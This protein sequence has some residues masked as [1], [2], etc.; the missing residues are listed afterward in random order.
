LYDDLDYWIFIGIGDDIVTLK[1]QR[2]EY[3]PLVEKFKGN[4]DVVLIALKQELAQSWYSRPTF[5]HLVKLNIKR[6]FQWK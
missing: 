3:L 4:P 5:W 6:M 2:P 1:D